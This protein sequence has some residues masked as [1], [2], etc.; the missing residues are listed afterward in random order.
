LRR[1]VEE[2]KFNFKGE[3][4]SVTVTIGCSFFPEEKTLNGIIEKADMALYKGK[5]EGKNK[6]VV[7]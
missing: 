4:V 2:E 6:V 5:R 7:C 1:G 3:T